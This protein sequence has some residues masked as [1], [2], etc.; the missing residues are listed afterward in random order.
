AP[1]R[2][3]ASAQQARAI[4]QACRESRAHTAFAHARP[5][6][7][8]LRIGYVSPDFRQ[9][10]VG[11]LV[12]PLFEL[13]DREAFEVYA[14]ALVQVDDAFNRRV[15]DGC[16]VYVDASKQSP[17]ET[18]RR[19]HADEIDVLIDLAGYTTYSRTAIFA[20]RPAPVQ[21]HWLGYLDTLGADFLPYVLADSRAVPEGSAAHYSEAIVALPDCFAVAAD[22]PIAAETPTREASGLPEDRF[23]FCS[24]NGFQKLDPRTFAAWMRILART[25]DSLLW[26]YEGTSSAGKERLR[27]EAERAGIDA[28]RMVFAPRGPVPEYLARYRLADLFLD[29]FDYNAGATALGALFAGL[30]LLTLPG[31]SFVSRMGASFCAAAALPDLVCESEAEYVERAVAIGRDRLLAASLKERLARAHATAPLFDGPRF[32]RRLES[33]YRLMWRDHLEGTRPRPIRVPAEDTG[34]GSI[35]QKV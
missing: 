12:A 14:Y 6:R 24:M 32:V 19:I 26:L 25:P 17:E 34:S 29:S 13:H 33:A 30:P 4:A 7:D 18:A 21:A 8:R 10:A 2:R 11:T 28:A 22:L 35:A 27:R 15:R 9:H 5:A 31:E 1:L 16:D 3:D 20:L 23:V